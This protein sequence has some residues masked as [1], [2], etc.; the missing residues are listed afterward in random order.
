MPQNSLVAPDGWR[1]DWMSVA[2]FCG[3]DARKTLR[4]W[5]YMT[6]HGIRGTL[7]RLAFLLDI[8]EEMELDST[9]TVRNYHAEQKVI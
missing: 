4:M 1:S 8:E 9:E 7:F 6:R 3:F 2:F 5:T